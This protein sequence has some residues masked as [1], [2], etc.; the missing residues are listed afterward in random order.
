MPPKIPGQKICHKGSTGCCGRSDTDQVS[1]LWFLSSPSFLEYEQPMNKTQLLYSIIR[2]LGAAHWSRPNGLL[3]RMQ[4]LRPGVSINSVFGCF[5]GVQL[6]SPI[7]DISDHWKVELERP[8]GISATTLHVWNFHKKKKTPATSY[9]SKIQ[10]K[11]TLLK[12]P[13]SIS[14]TFTLAV[15]FCIEQ[16]CCTWHR[17]LA[18]M[19][20]PWPWHGHGHPTFVLAVRTGSL[21]V[22]LLPSRR[23]SSGRP[24]RDVQG[25]PRPTGL[26]GG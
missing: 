19:P 24:T 9:G 7:S 21:E 6:G 18:M 20:W 23:L 14:A 2:H 25:F 12:G 26:V 17:I 11:R 3:G 8:A 10:Q 16:R 15:H 5:W 22:R 1:V 4:H 13:P